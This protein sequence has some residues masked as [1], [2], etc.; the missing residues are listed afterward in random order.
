MT[1]R[2]G[3]VRHGHVHNPRAVHYGRLPG[4]GL[5][6]KGHMQAQAAAQALRNVPVTALYSSPLQR[7]QETA[8]AIHAVHPHLTP[9]LSPLL[10]EVYT[11]FDGQPHSVLAARQWDAYT[12]TPPEYEQPGDV[13]DRARRFI[14]QVR[15]E[16]KG[17]HI[18][19]T[20]HGD[21]I[22]FLI[23]WVHGLPIDPQ[24]KQTLATLDIPG[25]YPGPASITTLTYHTA[26]PDEIPEI[27]HFV[28]YAR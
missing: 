21:I 13:L 3:F 27:E 14:A 15:Q 1:I 17:Q 28:P 7:A 20:T 12:G 26:A 16:S 19:A 8:A 22:S 11:P 18:I 2:I 9:V 25:N 10:S 23:L 4:F 24:Y 6:Q 5:S